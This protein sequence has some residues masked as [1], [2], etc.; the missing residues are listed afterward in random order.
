M[1]GMDFYKISYIIGKNGAKHLVGA[2]WNHSDFEWDPLRP[3]TY[4]TEIRRKYECTIEEK[5]FSVDCWL[6]L[7]HLCGSK[8]LVNLL[9][10]INANF[11]AVPFSFLKKSKGTRNLIGEYYII[12]LLDSVE[13][14]DVS[15]SKYHFLINFE[16]GKP[17][18]D[19][20]SGKNVYEKIDSFVFRRDVVLPPVST[21]LETGWIMVNK[22][23]T[24]SAQ[25][26][27]LIGPTFEK[28]DDGISYDAF[29]G[30]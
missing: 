3:S 11:R 18:I 27:A 8:K 26:I 7:P 5:E 1:E 14:L 2:T 22:L 15:K 30:P 29:E 6:F 19:I 21:C 17:V 9:S 23:F 4:N 12:L 28:L 24:E 20:E 25:E 16:T 13:L 10:A